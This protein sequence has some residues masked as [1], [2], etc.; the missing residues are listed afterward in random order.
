M[1]VRWHIDQAGLAMWNR[2]GRVLRSSLVSTLPSFALAVA[3]SIVLHVVRLIVLAVLL[4]LM[5]QLFLAGFP[6]FEET[7]VWLFAC[8]PGLLAHIAGKAK[9]LKRK[10]SIGMSWFWLLGAQSRWIWIVR[11]WQLQFTLTRCLLDDLALHSVPLNT[12]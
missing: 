2:H 4:L 6:P 11:R 12:T 3:I 8:L 5:F 7:G 10:G 1:A 9:L